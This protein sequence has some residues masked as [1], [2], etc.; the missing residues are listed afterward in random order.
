MSLRTRRDRIEPRLQFL[1][2]RG[3]LARAEH[4]SDACEQ[5]DHFATPEKLFQFLAPRGIHQR[6]KFR[7]SR[8]LGGCVEKIRGRPADVVM[9]A[10]RQTQRSLAGA[11]YRYRFLSITT[12]N[13]EEII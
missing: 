11:R 2:Q 5:I 1:R 10:E 4:G 13:S 3:K 12:E 8:S 7:V 9:L 6:A